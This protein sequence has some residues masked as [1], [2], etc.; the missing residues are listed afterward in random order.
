MENHG[1]LEKIIKGFRRL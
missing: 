1:G